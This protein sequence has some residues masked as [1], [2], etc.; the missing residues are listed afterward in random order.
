M[1]QNKTSTYYAVFTKTNKKL[2][3]Q[4]TYESAEKKRRK[5]ENIS[6]DNITIEKVVLPIITGYV[7]AIR[8]C[9]IV[10]LAAFIIALLCGLFRNY[11]YGMLF[12]IP[13][14]FFLL[15]AMS[16]IKRNRRMVDLMAYK[17]LDD[18]G[19]I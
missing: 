3:I 12:L 1:K 10:S 9:K 11:I 17:Q 8:L 4:D 5:L 7:E 6:S 19:K 18:E 16:I 13:V 14:M 15:M 2:Y